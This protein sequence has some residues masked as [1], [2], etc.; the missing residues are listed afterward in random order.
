MKSA[1]FL[2]A[3]EMSDYGFSRDFGG[4]SAFE[5]C[6]LW[7][8]KYSRAGKVA[9]AVT[10]HNI[11]MVEESAASSGVDVETICLEK[12]DTKTLVLEMAKFASRCGC[13]Y[14]L[15]SHG[16]RPFINEDLT[17]QIIQ[18]HEKYIAEYTFQDGYPQG[19]APEAINCGTLSIL[20]TLASD[21]K[22]NAGILPV[23][24][25]SIFNVLKTDINSFEVETVIAP[26]DYRMLRLNFSCTEKRNYQ[27]CKALWN[28]AE[29]IKN[30]DAGTLSDMASGMT[31]VHMT[32]PA[33]YEVQISANVNTVSSFSP[34]PSFFREKFNVDPFA[35][36]NKEN[37]VMPLDKFSEIVR[38]ISEFSDDAVV[39]L[40]PF[41]E[42]FLNENIDL[43]IEEVLKYPHLKV[44][45][46]T[47]G[48]LVT[49][50]NAL[51]IR[52][53]VEKC[54]RSEKDVT[55][56]V[57]I[58]SVSAD[59][60]SKLNLNGNFASCFNSVG[61]LAAYFPETYPQFTR[62]KDN[63]SELESFFRFWRDKNSPSR[64][65]VIIQKYNS[66]CGK[67]PDK[68][69]ADLSPLERNVC[70]H[71]K[72]DMII[73]FDGTVPLCRQWGFGNI[74]GNAFSEKICDIWNKRENMIRNHIDS[75]YG[76]LCGACDEFYTFNF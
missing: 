19:L 76:D 26:K 37:S 62:M 17:N 73:L 64:G 50:E 70:W 3:D 58:D 29:G 28:K 21:E 14:V 67:L 63:E 13:D 54:G 48:T 69:S 43:Y 36:S 18:C 31:E 60:Y 74:Q 1:V 49:E 55:F 2:F 12:W 40:S 32:L 34:Y 8:G 47:D 24:N 68:K 35:T 23:T 38:Q 51:R 6:L 4:K 9:V 72:R 56:I 52:K 53:S 45:V 57:M 15:Y 66:Y 25:E 11:K 42:P 10:S 16:D 44:L 5:L 7:A 41:G 20:S 22:N 59:M 33:Y 75:N 46:E 61:I 27:C 39:S 65:K 71:L 30:I